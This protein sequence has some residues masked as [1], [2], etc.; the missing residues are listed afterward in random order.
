VLAHATTTED[1]S[2]ALLLLKTISSDAI[3]ELWIV[4]RI[5][6]VAIATLQAF[7]ETS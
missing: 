2:F 6:V 4:A 1:L 3:C 7:V 5:G